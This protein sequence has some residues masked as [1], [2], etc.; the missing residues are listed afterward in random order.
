MAQVKSRAIAR[1]LP[2]NGKKKAIIKRVL[3][4]DYDT[5]TARSE[6]DASPQFSRLPLEL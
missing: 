2:T 3:V 4:N 6:N 1:N 5:K